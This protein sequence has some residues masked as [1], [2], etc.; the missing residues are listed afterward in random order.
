V[1][2]QLASLPKTI[3]AAFKG[4]FFDA[5]LTR[6]GANSGSIDDPTTAAA[7]VYSC[8]ALATEYGRGIQGTALV[9]ATDMNILI[10]AGSLAVQP[11]PL[12]RIAITSQSISGV[13]YGGADGLKAVTSDPAQATWQ[14]RVVT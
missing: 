14:C 8:K 5:T 13:I 6:D 9:G 10:L 4:I 7:T 1:V 3:N 12:D 11:E 2:S